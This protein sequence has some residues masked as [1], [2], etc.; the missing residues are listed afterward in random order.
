MITKKTAV[1]PFAKNK[2]TWTGEEFRNINVLVMNTAVMTP[3]I[4]K[5]DTMGFDPF[6]QIV[7]V[8]ITIINIQSIQRESFWR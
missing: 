5:N 3:K 7:I 2:S 6:I 8:H 1:S 4:F